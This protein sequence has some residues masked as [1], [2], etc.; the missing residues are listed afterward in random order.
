MSMNIPISIQKQRFNLVPNTPMARKYNKIYEFNCIYPFKLITF[1]LK[2]NQVELN[3]IYI[4]SESIYKQMKLKQKGIGIEIRNKR[5]QD[6][7]ASA[8]GKVIRRIHE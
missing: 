8:K 4:Q 2:Q 7:K 1:E 6:A 3:S 5:E